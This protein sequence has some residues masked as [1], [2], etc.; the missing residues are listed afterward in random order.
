[1]KYKRINIE[2]IDK[3]EL[4][5]KLIEKYGFPLLNFA[6]VISD[7]IAEHSIFRKTINGKRVSDIKREIEEL[8]KIKQGVI[9]KLKAYFFKYYPP[10]F[11]K[12]LIK[13]NPEQ[14]KIFFISEFKLMPF[15]DSINKLIKSLKALENAL[16]FKPDSTMV[17]WPDF[18]GEKRSFSFANQISFFWVSVIRDKNGI[19]WQSI[20]DLI[21]WF[22]ENLEDS[23]Y[24]SKL[25]FPHGK[26]EKEIGGNIDVLKN[27]YQKIKIQYFF[28][29]ILSYK[30]IHFPIKRANPLFP[31]GSEIDLN[32]P[33]KGRMPVISIKFYKNKIKTIFKE[34]NN[35]KVRETV[36]EKNK[37]T[38]EIRNYHQEEEKLEGENLL[39]EID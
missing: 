1:M 12:S 3:D 13:I 30:Y 31:M 17:L 34:N 5:E 14:R 35:L 33:L 29:I 26:E 36:F 38:S 39:L 19:H 8:S 28:P 20:L 25:D 15:F 23:T 24:E 11:Y 9:D 2:E 37:P 10:D 27:Q 32:D 7:V 6:S 21:S 22:L 18:K 16:K 4:N